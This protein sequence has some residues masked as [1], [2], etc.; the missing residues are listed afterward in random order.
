MTKLIG[1]LGGTFDPVHYGHLK[2]AAELLQC[3]PLD[4]IRF[5]PNRM[6]P[7]R[8]Q[9]VLDSAT[10]GRLVQLAIAD[11]PQFVMDDRELRRDGPSFMVDT[12]AELKTEQ[13]DATLCLIMGDDAFAGFTRWRRW[14]AILELCHLIVISRPG[15]ELPCSVE[16]QAELAPRLSHNPQ[17]L[18]GSQCG[19][20]LLQS[21]T[22][23][24]ISA[25]LI[26][27]RL[28]AGQSIADLV[29]ESI[30]QQLETHY[31]I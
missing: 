22:P 9:P 30:Q 6:P 16:H 2:P 25:T 26:R 17:A 15:A 13:P 14:Q 29:P 19:Q 20:I 21:I 24:P 18:L 11:N 27:Q 10:R 31:A 7:H 5:I 8:E 4:E 1:I 23:V 28:R 12:L 3:L